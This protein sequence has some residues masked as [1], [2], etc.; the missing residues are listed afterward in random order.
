MNVLT[1]LAIPLFLLGLIIALIFAYLFGNYNIFLNT[2]SE[3]GS[4]NATPFPM[5]MNGTFMISPLFLS[6]FF[7]KLFKIVYNYVKEHKTIKNLIVFAFSL[8][9]IMNI[10]FFLT[11]IFNVDISR[12]YHNICASF[13]FVPLLIGEIIVGIVIFIQRIFHPYIS[14]LMV[15]GQALTSILYFII[16][17]PLL[18]WIIFFVLLTWGVPL[19]IKM[20][21]KNFYFNQFEKLL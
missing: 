16:Q 12:L 8:F 11:G 20:I 13:V 7:I 4:F 10:A 14:I 5:I 2:I 15:F 3:L 6:F 17:S 9:G 1:I 18:E 21:K 19:S